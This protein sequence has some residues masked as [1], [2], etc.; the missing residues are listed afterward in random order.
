M[1]YLDR[2]P[3]LG[4]VSPLEEQAKENLGDLVSVFLLSYN[5]PSHAL[6][7]ASAPTSPVKG[8]SSGLKMVSSSLAASSSEI[9]S[10]SFG[11]S[12]RWYGPSPSAFVDFACYVQFL[13]MMGERQL[14]IRGFAS[15]SMILTPFRLGPFMKAAALRFRL[16]PSFL[17]CTRLARTV[18]LLVP[19]CPRT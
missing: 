4:S 19:S 5:A 13:F 12:S 8:G 10:R 1:S 18:V 11:D 15:T 14:A 3:P 16:D 9:A 2:F 7:L 17:L 6:P